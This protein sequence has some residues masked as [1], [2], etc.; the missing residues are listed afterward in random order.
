[1]D[2]FLY[3][4]LSFSDHLSVEVPGLLA[5]GGFRGVADATLPG[6]V[7]GSRAPRF[8]D[9]VLTPNTASSAAEL[10]ERFVIEVDRFVS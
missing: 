10:S 1:M 6:S 7:T 4:S 5:P 9:A 8:P 3:S 2:R